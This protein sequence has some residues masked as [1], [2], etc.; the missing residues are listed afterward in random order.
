MEATVPTTTGT[1]F[2][3]ALGFV[4]LALGV[5]AGLMLMA[6]NWVL[7]LIPALAIAGVV[8]RVR[9]GRRLALVLLWLL[10]LIGVGQMLPSSESDEITGSKP[11][12]LEVVLT[13]SAI[14]SS[15][16]LLGL[17]LLGRYAKEFRSSWF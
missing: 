4:C 11:Q 6:G 12:P 17:H 16:A 10:L 9:W 15:I 7:A 13:K 2:W 5:I 8:R 3:L 14:F 1:R